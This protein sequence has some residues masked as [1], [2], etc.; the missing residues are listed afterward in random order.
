[1]VRG[2]GR[3]LGEPTGEELRE[4]PLR[5]PLLPP[6]EG[7]PGTRSQKPLMGTGTPCATAIASEMQGAMQKHAR[8]KLLQGSNV[9]RN[10]P[11]AC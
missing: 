11:A 7:S 3:L 4:G 2:V 6:E 9:H 10:Q 5:R 8:D 1:M